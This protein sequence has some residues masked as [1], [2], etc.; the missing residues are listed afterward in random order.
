MTQTEASDWKTP[1]G[2][3][4]RAIAELRRGREEIQA[5]LQNLKQMQAPAIDLPVLKAELETAQKQVR[6]LQEELEIAKERMATAERAAERDRTELESLKKQF[7]HLQEQSMSTPKTEETAKVQEELSRLKEQLSE[8]H[9]QW[10]QAEAGEEFQK[11]VLQ[12]VSELRSRI[13]QLSDELTLVSPVSGRDYARLR[14]LLAAGEWQKADELT[15]AIVLDLA[16][17]EQEG[18]LDRKQIAALPW[19]DLRILNRLWVEYSEG[20]FGFSVQKQ[21]WQSIS[22]AN[23]D[24]FEVE[25][26]LGD[27]L[28]WRSNNTWLKYGEFNGDRDTAPLGHLPSTA[29]LMKLGE[30]KVED[31]LRL[32]FSRPELPA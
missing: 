32:F 1:L 12:S 9:A 6:A 13:S 3:Y 4:E 28:G 16:G 30:G 23:N 25:M 18:W 10:Q 31:R 5:E 2:Y 14:D 29:S 22:V 8:V 24:H 27:R 26:I 19:Q 21:I 11:Q 20:H 17:R 7:E 15:R